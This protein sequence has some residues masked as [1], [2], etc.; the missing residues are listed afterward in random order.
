M[1]EE[2]RFNWWMPPWNGKKPHRSRWKMT[3]EE[4]VKHGALVDM[5]PVE[6]SR[7]VI[8]LPTTREEIDSMRTNAWQKPNDNPGDKSGIK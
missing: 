3:R 5:G 6:H 1:R 4:A 2:E 7:E 8:Q